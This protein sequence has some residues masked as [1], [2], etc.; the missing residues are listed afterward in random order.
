M[1][2]APVERAASAHG[3]EPVPAD[4]SAG[5]A[6]VG[7]DVD[8]YAS[9]ATRELYALCDEHGARQAAHAELGL[10][11]WR[12]VLSLLEGLR[13]A[14]ERV[15]VTSSDHEREP[16]ERLDRALD[17]IKVFLDKQPGDAATPPPRPCVES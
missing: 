9:D 8:D 15:A 11:G 4:R 12:E 17:H 7:D 6:V 10:G 3:N 14:V 2:A 16:V 5:C 1:A 13:L